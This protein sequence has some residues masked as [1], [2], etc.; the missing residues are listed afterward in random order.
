MTPWQRGA[1]IVLVTVLRHIV[2]VVL[3]LI[4]AVVFFSP[5]VNLRPTTLRAWRLAVMI[6]AA[7]AAAGTM[8]SQPPLFAFSGV[9]KLG[10]SSDT[11]EGTPDLVALKCARLC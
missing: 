4:V 9:A 10:F 5:I 7:L 1:K 11:S 3:L 2:T 6:A 8:L